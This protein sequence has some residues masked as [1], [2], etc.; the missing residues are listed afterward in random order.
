MAGTATP[1]HQ[2][3]LQIWLTYLVSLIISASLVDCV[4]KFCGFEQHFAAQEDNDYDS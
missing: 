1:F 4:I 2:I 3:S